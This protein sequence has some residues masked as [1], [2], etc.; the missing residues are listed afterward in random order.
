MAQATA[1]FYQN[2]L[3]KYSLEFGKNIPFSY[4]AIG[5]FGFGFS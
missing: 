2:I 5:P 1:K 4:I 3:L